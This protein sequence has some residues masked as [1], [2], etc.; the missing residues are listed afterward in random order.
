MEMNFFQLFQGDGG[1]VLSYNETL[2]QDVD[3][4]GHLRT[5]RLTQNTND[6]EWDKHPSW[7]EDCSQV[8][9]HSNRSGQDQIW[10]MDFWSMEYDGQ[11]QRQISDGQFNDWNQIWVK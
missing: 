4:S 7:S 3:P 2:L 11:N 5:T 9:F 1:Q 6:W 8:I 10:I